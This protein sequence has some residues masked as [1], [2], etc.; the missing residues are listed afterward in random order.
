MKPY[1]IPILL[2]LGGIFGF[3]LGISIK[4][5]QK[6]KTE[7]VQKVTDCNN[8]GYQ[9]DT[10]VYYKGDIVSSRRT[11]KGNGDKDCIPADSIPAVKERERIS[12]E[13]FLTIYKTIQ[14]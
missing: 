6:E 2:L 8:A 9:I 10:Y 12:A 4:H 5:L 11:W 13:H 3:A 1:H 7:I 14:K